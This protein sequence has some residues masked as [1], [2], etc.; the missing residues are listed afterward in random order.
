[1][2]LHLDRFV[3]LALVLGDERTPGLRLDRTLGL[4]HD[5]ELAVRLHL[6]DEHRLVQV[7]TPPVLL[8]II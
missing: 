2:R 8:S 6:A 7:V 1:M 4:P 3:L 5:V